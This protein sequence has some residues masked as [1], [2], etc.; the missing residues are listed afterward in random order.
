[1]SSNFYIVWEWKNEASKDN[2]QFI[3]AH[4]FGDDY[5]IER[6]CPSNAKET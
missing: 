2:A 1:M 3:K 5:V 4:A 6:V